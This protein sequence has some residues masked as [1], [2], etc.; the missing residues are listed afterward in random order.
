M[1]ANG[2]VTIVWANGEDQF[3][4]AKVGYILDLETKCGAPIGVLYQRLGNGSFG[5]NDVRET[6]RLGLMGGGMPPDKAMAAV[7]HHV[8]SN[9]NGLAPSVLVA[10]EVIKAVMFGSPPDDPV[11]KGMPAEAKKTGFTTTTDASDALK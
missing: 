10:F 3:C 5:L 1:S 4:L 11:G 2:T 6:I 9:E 7:K 8:D